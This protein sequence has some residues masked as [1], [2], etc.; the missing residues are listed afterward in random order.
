[1]N[2]HERL[3]KAGQSCNNRKL[4]ANHAQITP[5]KIDPGNTISKFFKDKI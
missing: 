4:L 2:V 3:R 5:K 1:M